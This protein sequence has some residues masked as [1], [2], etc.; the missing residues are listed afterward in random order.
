[1]LIWLSLTLMEASLRPNKTIVCS[2]GGLF[3]GPKRRWENLIT[4][5][6]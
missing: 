2:T 3:L 6:R 5:R 4:F 1:M